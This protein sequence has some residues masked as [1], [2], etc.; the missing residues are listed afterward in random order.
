VRRRYTASCYFD[1]QSSSCLYAT[2]HPRAGWPFPAAL[3]F[4][5]YAALSCNECP[6][7]ARSS[8]PGTWRVVSSTRPHLLIGSGRCDGRGRHQ[9]ARR[10]RLR[11]WSVHHDPSARRYAIEAGVKILF[12]TLRSSAADLLAYLP[13]YPKPD[14]KVRTTDFQVQGGGNAGNTLTGWVV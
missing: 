10:R 13:V 14:D 12:D 11:S 9:G 6:A 5:H 8:G 1:L 7:S 4:I 3:S 2:S